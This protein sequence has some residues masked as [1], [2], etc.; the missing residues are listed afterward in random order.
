MRWVGHVARMRHEKYIK[1]VGVKAWRK[2]S[3]RKI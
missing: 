2:E 3:T 1:N